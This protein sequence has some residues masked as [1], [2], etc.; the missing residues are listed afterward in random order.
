MLSAGFAS[1]PSDYAPWTTIR[2]RPGTERLSTEGLAAV[3]IRNRPALLR[4]LAARGAGTDADDLFQELWIKAENAASGP[5]AEPLAYLYR[6][7]DNLMLD[8]RRAAERRIRRDD[9]WNAV[10]GGDAG[11]ASDQPSAERI[12]LARER[13]RA[14]DAKLVSLGERTA[15]IFRRY[16]IDGVRQQDIAPE[17]GISLSSVEKH[18]RKAYRAI[19]DMQSSLDAESTFP[20]R[21]G[22]EGN[23][24]D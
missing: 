10:A 4:F 12:L 24:D 9:Q 17:F 20:R 16:R 15:A 6:M 11:S 13:L 1:G 22:I 23:D 8:R 3:A 18:L 19:S 5:I 14:V 7:A 21:P 2:S